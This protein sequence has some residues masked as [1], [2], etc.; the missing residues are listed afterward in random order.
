M[1]AQ[2]GVPWHQGMLRGKK[3]LSPPCN[4]VLCSQCSLLASCNQP[5][6]ILSS[7]SECGAGEGARAGLWV[8]AAP[9][10]TI[11]PFNRSLNYGG[12]GT[13]IGH[14]LTHGYDDWGER[15]PPCWGRGGGPGATQ[16]PQHDK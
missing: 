3:G 5:S 7:R 8:G 2:C 14:E 4:V 12:I 13:I 6:M 16:L 9:G 1:G 10:V 11:A 15:P